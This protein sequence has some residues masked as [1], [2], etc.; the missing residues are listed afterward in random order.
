MAASGAA[1]TIPSSAHDKNPSREGKLLLS[2]FLRYLLLLS[3]AFYIAQPQLA[4]G[5]PGYGLK[6]KI[7]GTETSFS[8]LFASR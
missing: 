8:D 2:L 4:A 1:R 5:G 7:E 3:S 6:A